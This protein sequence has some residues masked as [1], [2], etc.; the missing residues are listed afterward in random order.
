MHG[1]FGIYADTFLTLPAF[2]MEAM[3][4]NSKIELPYIHDRRI[5]QFLES[6]IKGGLSFNALRF[7]KT[8]KPEF[9][10]DDYNHILM[11]DANSLNSQSLI[12]KLPIGEYSFLSDAEVASFDLTGKSWSLDD[13]YG[14][15]IQCDILYPEELHR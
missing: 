12:S 14:Y 3:L 15:F 1:L 9:P 5:Y 11:V 8:K 4:Y 2:S 13:D 7:A 6:S 10:G